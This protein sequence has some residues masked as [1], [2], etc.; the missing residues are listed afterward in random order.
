MRTTTSLLLAG[1][2]LCGALALVPVATADPACT[3]D[4]CG[5]DPNQPPAC[6][7]KTYG[8][9]AG[10]SVTVHS[11]CTVLLETGKGLNC[12]GAWYGTSESDVGPVHWTRHYCTFPGGDP[13]CCVS[14]ASSASLPDAIPPCQ[15]APAP[16]CE[17]INQMLAPGEGPVTYT[18]SDYCAATVTIDVTKVVDCVFGTHKTIQKGPVTVIYPVCSSPCGPGADY[19]PPPADTSS[20]Q[21]IPPCACPPPQPLCRPVNQ[22]I[23][24]NDDGVDYTLS[25][26]CHPTVSVDLTYYV[27]CLYGSSATVTAGPVSVTYPTGCSPPPCEGGLDSCPPPPTDAGFTGPNY[28]WLKADTPTSAGPVPVNPQAALWGSD[29]YVDVN[30]VA[31]CAPPSGFVIERLI[32]P[33]HLHLLV[34]DGGVGQRVDDLLA[35]IGPLEA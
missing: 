19:C 34:C 10:D 14:S 25:D 27:V 35:S 12:V 6:T 23:A 32:G 3:T 22:L 8:G 29:C 1:L 15:C 26:Y 21:A 18:L 16:L 9:A 11:D 20:A 28:C 5:P 17:P 31:A 30:P 7:E 24:D 33:V 4:L 2:L 13:L